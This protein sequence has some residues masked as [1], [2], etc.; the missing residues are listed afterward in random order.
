MFELAIPY[1]PF[2]YFSVHGVITQELS[3]TLDHFK[4]TYS[5]GVITLAI[6]IILIWIILLFMVKSKRIRS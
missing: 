3:V 4:I 6:S 2:N 5:T 1:D